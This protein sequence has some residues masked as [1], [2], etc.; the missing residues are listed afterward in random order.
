MDRDGNVI[1]AETKKK[2]GAFMIAHTL[3][4]NFFFGTAAPA[5]QMEGAASVGGKGKNIWD[6]WFE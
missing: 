5:T 6:Y 1:I 3:F 2:A 4:E